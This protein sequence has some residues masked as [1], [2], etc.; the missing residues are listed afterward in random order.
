MH[1]SDCSTNNGPA[2][3]AGPCDCTETSL[4]PTE[5]ALLLAGCALS[6]VGSSFIVAGIPQWCWPAMA[7]GGSCFGY[8][9]CHIVLRSRDH[10]QGG[11]E[12]R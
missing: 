7:A 12:P 1:D 4:K 8:A 2:L 11:P 9:T 10:G 3:P 6:L 5:K